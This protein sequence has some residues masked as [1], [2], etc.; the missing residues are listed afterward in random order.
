MYI[1]NQYHAHGLSSFIV[2]LISFVP[3]FNPIWT[4][5]PKGPP[6][7][8]SKYLKNGLADLH[9]TLCLLRPLYRSSFKM[10]SLSIGHSLLPW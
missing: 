8:F 2:L 10:K 5:G 6:E 3:Y 4:G 9:E 7:G 1:I